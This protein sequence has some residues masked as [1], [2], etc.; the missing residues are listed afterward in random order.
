MAEDNRNVWYLAVVLAVFVALPTSLAALPAS[1]A[2]VPAAV[3]TAAGLET[4]EE[5]CNEFADCDTE[6]FEPMFLMFSTTCGE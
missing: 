5:A 4:C 2:V 6:C 1:F 3:A